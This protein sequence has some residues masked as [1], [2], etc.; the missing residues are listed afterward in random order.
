[1]S[2][3]PAACMHAGC[4]LFVWHQMYSLSVV[5]QGLDWLCRASARPVALWHYILHHDS[6][7]KLS[8]CFRHEA[9]AGARHCGCT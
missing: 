1:M 4:L 8:N 5:L 7:S 9:A 6:M 3:Q 2:P